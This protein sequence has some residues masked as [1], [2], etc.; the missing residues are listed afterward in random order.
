MKNR[1]VAT[2]I[3]SLASAAAAGFRGIQFNFGS[4]LLQGYNTK[5][6]RSTAQLTGPGGY[7]KHP[8]GTVNQAKRAAIKQKNRAKYRRACRGRT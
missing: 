2:I 8:A 6:G 4:D 5:P 1:V 3:S 7:A